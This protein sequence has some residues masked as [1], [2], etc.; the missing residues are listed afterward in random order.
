MLAHQPRK[1]IEYRFSGW[2]GRWP[3]HV[4]E[5]LRLF[6]AIKNTDGQSDVI[7]F[8]VTSLPH[9]PDPWSLCIPTSLHRQWLRIPYSHSSELTICGRYAGSRQCMGWD[10]PAAPGV[11]RPGVHHTMTH[12]PVR[13]CASSFLKAPGWSAPALLFG[14]FSKQLAKSGHFCPQVFE[15]GLWIP[16]LDTDRCTNHHHRISGGHSQEFPKTLRDQQPSSSH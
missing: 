7:L 13:T 9:A 10:D 14:Q 8:L 1:P 15:P 2:P 6:N 3:P 5:A 11:V 16:D 12:P 4:L